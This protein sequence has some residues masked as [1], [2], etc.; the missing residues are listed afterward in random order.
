MID[1]AFSASTPRARK[2]LELMADMQDCLQRMQA[3]PDNSELHWT[4]SYLSGEM[5]WMGSNKRLIQN[6]ISAYSTQDEQSCAEALLHSMCAKS[7]TI[8]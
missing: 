7:F 6:Y 2:A 3:E 1:T 8:Y 4:L 5:E